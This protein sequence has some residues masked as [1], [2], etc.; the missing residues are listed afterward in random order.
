MQFATT[1]PDE[2]LEALAARVYDFGERPPPAAVRAAAKALADANPILRK[3]ADV[4][5]GTVVEVPRLDEGGHRAGATQGEDA[6]AA[7]LV[8]DHVQAAAALVARQL[9]A[10][11][12]AETADAD[13]TLQLA[14]S[15]ELKRLDAPGLPEA[16]KRTVAAAEARAASAKELRSRQDAMLGQLASDLEELAAVHGGRTGDEPK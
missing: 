16:L 7:G 10:D 15:D 4:P 1:Q 11:L 2:S 12:D 9:A 6:V 5:P 13:A 14:R 3:P 8:L